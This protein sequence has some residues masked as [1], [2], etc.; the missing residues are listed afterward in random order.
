[1]DDNSP[2]TPT[3]SSATPSECAPTSQDQSTSS[4][5]YPR[6]SKSVTHQI[7]KKIDKMNDY[8]KSA[9][10]KSDRAFGDFNNSV[11]H[12]RYE[13]TMCINILMF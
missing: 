1:M 9:E 4:F 6:Y 13:Q 12:V 8:D 7:I 3:T 11:I 2:T 10:M 5:C